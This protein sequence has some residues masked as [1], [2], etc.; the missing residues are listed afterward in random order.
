M[1]LIIL[2][3]LVGVLGALLLAYGA[4]LIY[5]P[6]GFVVAGGL[7]LFWSWLVARYLDRTLPS[8]S[9]GK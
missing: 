3:P 6:A 7:C 4:W 2:A 8:V 5:P 9:G 1:F